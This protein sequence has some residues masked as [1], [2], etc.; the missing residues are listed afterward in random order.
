MS[1]FAIGGLDFLPRKG[2]FD[3]FRCFRIALKEA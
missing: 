1:K 2:R 3:M